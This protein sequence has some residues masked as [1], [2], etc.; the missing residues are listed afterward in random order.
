MQ[1]CRQA[2]RST[3][4]DPNYNPFSDGYNGVFYKPSNSLPFDNNYECVTN[5][6]VCYNSSPYS[7]NN[8]H[9]NYS[10]ITENNN[11][12][13]DGFKNALLK[14]L[15]SLQTIFEKIKIGKALSKYDR[16]TFNNILQFKNMII[17]PFLANKQK[18]KSVNT[19][20]ELKKLYNFLCLVNNIIQTIENIQNKKEQELNNYYNN[21]L[22]RYSIAVTQFI[23]KISRIR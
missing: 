12:Q 14:T 22:P 18:Y 8:K 21:K 6:P 5:K 2:G 10:T 11:V 16:H 7:Y 1:V 3:N 15:Q 19:E 13:P 4:N 23:I 20:A 17:K 9:I